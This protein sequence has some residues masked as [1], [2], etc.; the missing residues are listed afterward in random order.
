MQKV[1]AAKKREWLI[2]GS[3]IGYSMVSVDVGAPSAVA[4]AP[5]EFRR[6]SPLSP[7]RSCPTCRGVGGET[8]RGVH[9]FDGEV[10]G[11]KARGE[12]WSF[13]VRWR[14]GNVDVFSVS[15]YR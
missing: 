15:L 14:L 4:A 10:K 1:G 8:K 11:P 3:W 6:S 5:A 13:I 12:M 9:L 2:E 7:R